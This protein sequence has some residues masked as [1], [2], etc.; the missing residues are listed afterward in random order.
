M[1]W[2]ATDTAN[3]S[4]VGVSHGDAHILN[5]FYISQHSFCDVEGDLF[6]WAQKNAE[7]YRPP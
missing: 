6:I 4:A 5:Y 7:M 2:A 1:C 3:P